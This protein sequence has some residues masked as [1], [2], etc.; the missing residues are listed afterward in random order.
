MKYVVEMLVS[1]KPV[2]KIN[3]KGRAYLP[4]EA[5]EKFK[6]KITNNTSKRVLAVVSVDGL[7]VMN[8]QE[9]SHND[10]GYVINAWSHTVIDGWRKNDNEVA[11]FEVVDSSTPSYAERMG[12]GGNSGVIGVAIFPEQVQKRNYATWKQTRRDFFP[13]GP[14]PYVTPLDR[15]DNVY[16]DG[17][18][19]YC[20]NSLG[21]MSASLDMDADYER[22]PTGS[23]MMSRRVNVDNTKTCGII[24]TPQP[25]PQEAATGWG[26]TETSRVTEVTFVRNA[27]KKQVIVLYYD[28]PSAL[29]CKG[30]PLAYESPNPFP[31]Q[32]ERFYC[33]EPPQ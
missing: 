33:P 9:A 7:S 13:T 29:R 20:T 16:D 15:N 4:V 26:D 31:A 11:A 32:P 1:G 21:G 2:R 18:E 19:V 23:R 17:H 8:G 25:A 28:T 6:M 10:T 3:H 24:D 12:K 5:G 22:S 30:V 27:D 14:K